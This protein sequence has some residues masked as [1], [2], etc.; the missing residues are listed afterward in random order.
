[1]EEGVDWFV[2]MQAQ[3]VLAEPRL[4]LPVVPGLEPIVTWPAF[5]PLVTRVGDVPKP[6]LKF[7]CIDM[8]MPWETVTVLAVIVVLQPKPV[9][10]V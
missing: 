8:I 1:M 6:V 4:R 2:A 5:D 10:V 9:E 3:P 7:A